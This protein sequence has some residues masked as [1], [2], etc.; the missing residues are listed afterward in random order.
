[1]TACIAA[2]SLIGPRTFDLDGSTAPQAPPLLAAALVQAYLAISGR[3]VVRGLVSLTAL[4]AAAAIGPVGS[5]PPSARGILAAYLA[6]GGLMLIGALRRDRLAKAL[7]GV[8]VAGLVVTWTTPLWTSF[9]T[10]Q[11]LV[12]LP[13]LLAVIYGGMIGD[14]RFSVAVVLALLCWAGRYGSLAYASLR[15]VVPGLDQIALGLAFFLVAA[16]ISMAKAGPLLGPRRRPRPIDLA[17]EPAG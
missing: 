16:L 13:M 8:A 10:T 11:L 12:I 15:R 7:R 6:I 2:I 14:R 5:W 3:N 1:M 9:E 17:D 4:T